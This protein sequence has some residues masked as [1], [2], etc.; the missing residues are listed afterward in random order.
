MMKF[1]EFDKNTEA[2]GAKQRLAFLDGI[3]AL[4]AL[5]VMFSHIVVT[6]T[7]PSEAIMLAFAP[8]ELAVCIFIILSGYSLGIASQRRPT[9]YVTFIRRRAWRI[10][11]P[12]LASLIIS[13][14]LIE[15]VIGSKTGTHWD[16]VVPLSWAGVVISTLL[17]QDWIVQSHG[18]NFV[19]W[20]IA[21]E[22]HLYFVFPV[23]LLALRRMG[24]PVLLGMSALGACVLWAIWSEHRVYSGF[25]PEM[26]ILFV[27][28]LLAADLTLA[29]DEF[30][31]VF[32]RVFRPPFTV[33]LL[34]VCGGVAVGLVK[35]F[36][37]YL[38]GSLILGFAVSAF[39]IALANDETHFVRRILEYRPLVNIGF[40]SYSLYLIHAPVLQLVW[41][42]GVRPLHATETVAFVLTFVFGGIAS[43]AAGFAFHLVFERPF[44][45]HRSLRSLL[46]RNQM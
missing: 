10:L 33:A 26:L 43:L 41:Q 32:K 40:F 35:I 12:Y 9:T 25:A 1:T 15:T 19:F 24:R 8:S 17:L 2:T 30:A 34:V 11:P 36:P 27:F 28:G 37:D 31:T 45:N 22:W 13:V 3:R 46:R 44:L 42:Y 5:Y 39:M 16:E 21:V 20:S 6:Q 4:C 14:V 23:L 18:P 38:L 7:A 29:T